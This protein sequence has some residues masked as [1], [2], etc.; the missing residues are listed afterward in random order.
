MQTPSLYAH[1]A[2]ALERMD[3]HSGFA[4]FH[5]MGTGKTLTVLRDMQRAFEKGRAT[6]ALVVCPLSVIPSWLDQVEKFTPYTAT[7]IRGTAAKRRRS[8][9]GSGRITV[10]NYDLLWGHLD[11]LMA[12]GFDYL[13]ADESHR[14]ISPK[15]KWTRA[16][17]KLSRQAAMRR[18]LT[19][20]PIRKWPIDLYNQMR[21]I[22]PTILPWRSHFAFRKTFAIE[23]NMGGFSKII[24]VRNADEIERLCAPYCD[25]VAFDDAIDMPMWIDEQ[26]TVPMLPE[27]R[28][29]YVELSKQLLTEINGG[30]VTAQNAAVEL[31]RLSQISGGSIKDEQGATH[32]LG[33]KKIDEVRDILRAG[34]TTVIW[35]RF[36]A[37]IL[38]LKAELNCPGIY[39]GTPASERAEILTGFKNGEHPVIVC[40][41]QTLSEG[42]NELCN[43]DREIRWSYDWS[44]TTFVQS[45]ARMRRSGRDKQRPCVSIQLITE[46]STDARIVKAVLH[47]KEVATNTLEAI[48]ELLKS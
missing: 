4:M 6:K 12:C 47:K 10:I 45:R 1:Q 28:R 21:F 43:A 13:V 29:V 17:L 20:T 34:G 5:D 8:L 32:W 11:D 40:Q 3:S 16:M 31:L 19:G 2:A 36:I 15:T 7:A 27:Q 35:C 33:S 37:E 14:L 9:L 39:G 30:L 41:V 42:V 23:Q 25:Y 22:D 44:Y 46:N 18:A 38:K 26:R 48:R 24:G